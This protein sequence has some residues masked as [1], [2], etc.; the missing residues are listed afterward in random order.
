MAEYKKLNMRKREVDI[1]RNDL[2]ELVSSENALQMLK[3]GNLRFVGN[4]SQISTNVPDIRSALAEKG[5]KPYAIILGCSD[6][7]VPPE[8]VFDENLGQL[9]VVRTAGNVCDGIAIGSVEYAAE[10]LGSALVVVLGHEKCGAVKA[11]VDGGDAG[12]NIGQILN[13]ILPSLNIVKAAYH[14]DIAC[15]CED[16]NIKHTIA[17]LNE[18]EILT[19]LVEEG[20]LK[21]IGAKYHLKTG[22][23]VFFED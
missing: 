12:P 23:V 22:E 7:R 15:H 9:F 11:A 20:K 6:S 16:E 21:I 1:M 3:E 18:S 8:I 5:Q 4:R 17:R 19:H 13:E 14:D 10:H 2:F